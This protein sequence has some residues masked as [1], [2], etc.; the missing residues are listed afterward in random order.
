[1]IQVDQFC[2]ELQALGLAPV[3]EDEMLLLEYSFD[4]VDQ[5]AVIRLINKYVGFWKS[6]GIKTDHSKDDKI[7]RYKIPVL[8]IKGEDLTDDQLQTAVES[9]Q[10]RMGG[11]TKSQ[12]NNMK[13]AIGYK[14]ERVT[15]GKFLASRNF[16]GV[17]EELPEWEDLVLCGL[18]TKR[19]QFN[20]TVYHVSQKGLDFL[21]ALLDIEIVEDNE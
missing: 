19:Q 16:F 14:A 6:I 20:E 5:K 10:Q 4:A 11:I 13:Q 1:M 2:E 3:V 15:D 8:W 7:A 17:S 12:V 18:A 21:A 9:I